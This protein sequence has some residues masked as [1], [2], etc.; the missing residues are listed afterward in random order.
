MKHKPA[1]LA[2]IS[3]LLRTLG[4]VLLAALT[5]CNVGEGDSD[6]NDPTD[7]NLI[8][9]RVIDSITGTA[10]KNASIS[11]DPPTGEVLTNWEGKYVLK[12]DLIELGKVYRLNVDKAGYFPE[13]V[14]ITVN[15]YGNNI[16]DAQ[17]S[18]ETVGIVAEPPYL[19]FSDKDQS[20]SFALSSTTQGNHFLVENDRSWITVSPQNGEISDTQQRLITVSIDRTQLEPGIH[21][22]RL[23]INSNVNS[24]TVDII[25]A[26]EMDLPLSSTAEQHSNDST[27]SEGSPSVATVTTSTGLEIEAGQCELSETRTMECY[28]YV[29]SPHESQQLTLSKSNTRLD[30][31]GNNYAPALIGLGA[32]SSTA[33]TVTESLPQ[34]FPTRLWAVFENISL[35]SYQYLANH[36]AI[37]LRPYGSNTRE[38]IILKDL[39]IN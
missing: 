14:T 26:V 36:L 10:L 19:R 22:G 2:T 21:E 37:E 28:A 3:I 25:V 16:A 35:D 9:G 6:T 13:S 34:A 20:L 12:N 11:T 39:R 33:Y 7:P 15:P 17:L 23:I 32:M 30:I 29:T 31:G 1:Y 8:S 27:Y 5:A 4:M 18:R 38:I 24:I